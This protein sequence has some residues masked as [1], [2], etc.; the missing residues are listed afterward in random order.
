MVD[1]RELFDCFCLNDDSSASDQVD[2]KGSDDLVSIDDFNPFFTFNCDSV[3]KQ[4]EMQR[5]NIDPFRE[6]RSKDPMYGD[7]AADHVMNQRLRVIRKP[8]RNSEA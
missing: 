6:A 5:T 2:A 1:E 4:L 8:T 3:G 7:A